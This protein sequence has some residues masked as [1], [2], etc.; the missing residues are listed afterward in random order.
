MT[1]RKWKRWQ[2]ALAVFGMLAIGLAFLWPKAPQPPSSVTS[3]AQLEAYTEA[4]VNFGTPPGMSLVVVKNGEI[5]YSKGFGW[6][7]HP[8]QIAAT[9]QTVYHWWSCTKIVTAIAVLQL[10]EQGKLRLEDSVAQFLPFFKVH[11]PMNDSQAAFS[12]KT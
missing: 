11:C 4:L 9:P 8:R 3:V 1:L 7:D 12:G 5:V 6:A 10:Q 2:I